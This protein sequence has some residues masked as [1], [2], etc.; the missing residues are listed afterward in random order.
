[1]RSKTW[2][3]IV[4]AISAIICAPAYGESAVKAEQEL[5]ASVNQARRAQGMPALRWDESLV[6]AA[7][8]HAAVMAAHGEAQHQ[9]EGEPN[10]SARVKQTGAH[11]GWLSENVIVGTSA[12]EVHGQF[13]N[14]PNHRANILDKDMDSVGIGVVEHEGKLFA[15]EDFA[16]AH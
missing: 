10:L 1:M 4:I 2:F 7:R 13:M 5:F 12:E 11:V 9:F 3:A 6:T 16:Q 8:R 14:S 15:V